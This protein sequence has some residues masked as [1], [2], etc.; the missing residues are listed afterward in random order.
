MDDPSSSASSSSSSLTY[1][2]FLSFRGE[3]TRQS[4]VCHLHKAL[5]LK[6]LKV[7][8]D[9]ED[10]KKGDRLSDLLEAIAE[11]KLLIVV[12]S[13]NYG[14]STW[15]LKEL[16]QIMKCKEKQNQIVMPVFYKVDPSHIRKQTGSFGEAFAKHERDRE[17]DE[18]LL[19]EVQTW[20]SAL[21]KAADLSGWD[22]K[23]Y[24]DDA[25]LIDDIVKEVFDKVNRISPHIEDGLVAMDSHLHQV[26]RLLN[27]APDDV[28]CV[29]IW[30]MG[31]LGKTTIARAVYDRICHKFDHHCFLQNVR[32]G[33]TR[34]GE[35]KMQLKFLSGIL[36]E[37]V[38]NF[39]GGYMKML[40]R[41]GDKKILVVLDDVLDSSQIDTLLGE[42]RSFGGGSIIIVTTR[43]EH[44]VRGFEIYKPEPL[45]DEDA[46]NLF[47]QKA[48]DTCKPPGE[49]E[50]RSKLIVEYARGL[51]LALI[52]LGKFL[53]K[54]SVDHWEGQ[55]KKLKECP[56]ADIENV[57]KISYDGLEP[58]QKVIFLDIACF[59]KGMKKDYVTKVLD[60]CDCISPGLDLDVLVERALVTISYCK[61]LEMHDLLREMGR[62]IE[63]GRKRSRFWGEEAEHVLTENTATE[64]AGRLMIDLPKKEGGSFNTSMRIFTYGQSYAGDDGQNHLTGD[65]KFL[66]RELKV[67]VWHGYPQKC[68]PS[69]FDP[70]NLVLL[71]VRYSNFEQLWEGTKPAENLISINL[72]GSPY[73]KRIPN[74]T[75]ATNL[76]ELDFQ[77]CSSL[78]EVDPSISALKN[79]VFL[80]FLNCEELRSLPSIG[81]MKSL[82]TLHLGYCLKFEMFPEILE[83]MEALSTLKLT[84]TPIKELPS[85]IERLRGLKSLDMTFCGSLIRLPDSIC[86]LAELRDLS[87]RDCSKL[88][89]LPE[90]IGNLESLM[91]L[92]VYG[93]GLEQLPVSILRLKLARLLFSYC[94]KMA[95][96]LS[97]WPSSIEDCCTAVVHLDFRGCNL[98]E[99]SDAIAYFSSL[100]V[101]CLSGNENLESLPASMKRLDFLEELKLDGC[102]RLRSIPELSPTIR[103]INAHDC[104]A[105]ESVSTPQSP[106]D[107]SRCF[108]FSNCSQ[109]VQ[110]DVFRDIVET[111]LPPQRNCF[112]PFYV[113]FP[114]RKIPKWFTHRCR[115]SSVT[116]KL[117]PNW[118][119]NKLLGFTICAVTKKPQDKGRIVR[120]ICTFKGDHCKYRFSFY[121]AANCRESNHMLVGYMPWSESGM[122]K[123]EEVNE[124]RY[125]EAKFEIQWHYKAGFELYKYESS[126]PFIKRCGVRFVFANKEED[127]GEPMVEVDN[128]ERRLEGCS[129]EPSGS[130]ITSDTSDDDEQYLKLLSKVFKGA[131]RPP[132]YIKIEDSD[133]SEGSDITGDTSDEDEQYL[134]SSQA[135][136]GANRA[137][138]YFKIQDNDSSGKRK[139]LES[140]TQEVRV[141]S[142]LSQGPLDD[143]FVWFCCSFGIDGHEYICT[144]RGRVCW[145]KAIVPAH[146]DPT[147]LKVTFVGRHTCWKFQPMLTHQVR[148]TPAMK[149]EG[150]FDGFTWR[151]Y[152]Q[153]D[154]PGARYPRLQADWAAAGGANRRRCC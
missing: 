70:K 98:L 9:K 35:V 83:G 139:T 146:T 108:I 128:S 66:S 5:E 121:L 61:T 134:K 153:K 21:R 17:R 46:L 49:Y 36:N 90:N 130:G 116:A 72:S 62:K 23:N 65:F 30:G 132:S 73:L 81:H 6:A 53:R 147:I 124:R 122:I 138:S 15:C 96:P 13:E 12:F 109:L 19:Q 34:K 43:D 107:I 38:S 99:L 102:K 145:A 150:P 141:T 140:W 110:K 133:S 93:T 143:G 82:K 11:S 27:D 24:E 137:P 54:R 28:V 120:C 144:H 78:T 127:F 87:L 105:L 48:F 47:S 67:L 29:G 126:D 25:R 16:V 42:R 51:P 77:G 39:D 44:V 31:G 84:H 115:G 101:L 76:K 7:Y 142:G 14:N 112:R 22:S 26:G 52:V 100:K 152:D 20:R 95:A 119:D 60:N 92:R 41:L 85:S 154:M 117:P 111:H 71:D 40:K 103:Y 8:I 57:L 80:N 113:S 18:E 149:I 58:C 4:F 45:S 135:F 136:K 69:N 64:N 104:T 118:F 2:G 10:L 79:L 37:K 97:S 50:H 56:H 125:T 94:Q 106:Y 88:C 89:K 33:F 63:K 75:L 68:L 86:N 74:L 114:G 1:D 151:K 32:E 131:N 148:V 123:R 129:V 59:F 91:E 3:D 55:L